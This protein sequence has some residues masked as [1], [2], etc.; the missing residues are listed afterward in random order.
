MLRHVDATTLQFV[1]GRCAAKEAN[2]R[3]CLE[4]RDTQRLSDWVQSA[5]LIIVHVCS[6]Q[7]RLVPIRCWPME[8]NDIV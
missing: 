7:N 5:G 6:D 8:H 4:R 3:G 2:T 1:D